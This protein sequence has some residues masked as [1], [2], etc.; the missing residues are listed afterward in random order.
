MIHDHALGGAEEREEGL[1]DFEEAEDVDGEVGFDRGDGGGE[2]WGHVAVAGVVW[3]FGLVG[4]SG[5]GGKG[6]KGGG[7]IRKSRWP[8]VIEWVEATAAVMEGV[9]ITSSWSLESPAWVFAGGFR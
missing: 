9:D 2:E 3:T 6:G 7:L 1:C 8:F 5:G 4:V